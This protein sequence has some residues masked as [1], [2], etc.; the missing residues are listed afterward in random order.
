[1][2]GCLSWRHL[3]PCVGSVVG[4]WDVAQAFCMIWYVRWP[5]MF[6]HKIDLAL[7]GIS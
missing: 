3:A 2:E 6:L 1:M 4:K 7:F 5:C